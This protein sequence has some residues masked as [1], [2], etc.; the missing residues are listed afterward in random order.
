MSVYLKPFVKTFSSK[1]LLEEVGPVQTQYNATMTVYG[2]RLSMLNNNHP[3]EIRTAE[4]ETS[5]IVT[6][7]EE[8]SRA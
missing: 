6:L 4:L 5:N 1:G 2:G 3:A 7:K 8:V